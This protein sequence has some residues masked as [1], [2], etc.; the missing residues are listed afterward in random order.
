MTDDSILWSIQR[1]AQGG[2]SGWDWVHHELDSP[3]VKDAVGHLPEPVQLA[4][5][6]PET[7]PRCDAHEDGLILNLRG[8]NLNPG[9]NAEDM[10][11]IR[12]WV[13][14]TSVVSVQ[15]R[16][17]VSV[18]EMHDAVLAGN[19]P[20]NTGAFVQM[21]THKL[22]RRIER[23]TLAQDSH[24]DDLEDQGL[25]PDPPTADH[26]LTTLQQLIKLRRFVA[27]LREALEDL[28]TLSDHP[29]LHDAAQSMIRETGHKCTRAVESLDASRDRLMALKDHQ[30][31]RI[32]ER[33]ARNGYVL[34]VIAAIFL[35]L[36]FLT[37]LFGVNVGGMP[38]VD[39]PTAFAILTAGCCIAG[40]V[41]FVLLRWRRWL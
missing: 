21:L 8:I 35:P 36:G 15:R 13:T 20:E 34:S 2:V 41:L 25:T 26:L 31:G 22:V 29:V 3:T 30:D 24:I 10:V 11:S 6:A 17:L 39:M 37:G 16:S 12:L 14:A 40:V 33:Q 19:G 23:E 27:P 18:T 9:E 7:R 4:L 1:A 28:T 5:L 38:G 32:A